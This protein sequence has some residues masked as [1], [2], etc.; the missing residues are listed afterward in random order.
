MT[1]SRNQAAYDAYERAIRA[2]KGHLSAMDEAIEAVTKP[3][4]Q[5]VSTATTTA[6]V[7]GLDEDELP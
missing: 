5:L 4:E 2:G 3:V 6:D 7:G 1:I